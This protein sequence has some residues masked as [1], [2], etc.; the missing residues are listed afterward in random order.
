VLSPVDNVTDPSDT[1]WENVL[2]MI[3]AWQQHRG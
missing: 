1:V 3:E 2:A